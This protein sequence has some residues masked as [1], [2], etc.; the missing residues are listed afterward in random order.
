MNRYLLFCLT[1]LTISFSQTYAQSET[2]TIHGFVYDVK[3]NSELIGA[4]VIL[5]LPNTDSAYTITTT[6][7]TGEFIFENIPFNSYELQVDYFGYPHERVSITLNSSD[8]KV[9]DILL[10]EDQTVYKEVVI[11]GDII[12]NQQRG[13][14]LVFNADAYK[15]NPDATA[16]DLIRKMPGIDLSDGTPKA[17]GENIT[18]IYVDGKPFFGDDVNSTLKNLPAEMIQNVEIF[19]EKNEQSRFSGFDDGQTTKTIN[20]VTRENK[21]QGM[22][23]KFYA[24]YGYN[25]D[26]NYYNIG[27]VYNHFKG[28]Q[29]IT[30]LGM[31]NNINIQN[32]S[33]EDLSGGTETRG[34]GRGGA[35]MGM[36]GRGGNNF[37][38]NQ[39][40]GITTTN[41]VGMNYTN[42]WGTN[43]KLTGSYMFTNSKNYQTET[44]NRDYLS[45]VNYGQRYEELNVSNTE[46]FSHR[47]DFR[48]EYQIDSNNY[49]SFSPNLRIQNT[50]SS[51][52]LTSNTFNASNNLLSTS[53]NVYNSENNS[54]NTG[55][56]FLYNHNFQKKGRTFSI[57]NNTNFNSTNGN[58]DLYANNTFVD[59]VDND[60]LRQ[61]GD[62][63]RKGYN[64]NVNVNYTEPLSDMWR[65]QANVGFRLQHTESDKVTNDFNSLTNEYD[66]LNPK[67]SNQFES[68][69]LTKFAGVAVGYFKENFQFNLGTNFQIAD[70]SSSAILPNAYEYENSFKNV[71]PYAAITYT[72]S[73]TKS[74]R[75]R[76][77]TSTNTPSINQLQNV[78]DNSNTMIL[79]TG[80]PNLDQNYDHRFF[81]N[82]R[83]N[84]I[85]KNSNFFAMMMLNLTNDYVGN[86]T[87]IANEEIVIDDI[88]LKP[89]MQYI[90]PINMDGY[91]RFMTHAVYSFRLKPIKSNVNLNMLYSVSN[92][93]GMV[94]FVTNNSLNSRYGAGVNIGSNISEDIDFNIGTQV[95][96]NTLRN[97]MNTASN[98]S[99]YNQSTRLDL[100]YYIMKNLFFNTQLNHQYYTGLS[101]ENN[102]NF[103]LWNMALG[104][105]FLKNNQAE[106]KLS[107]FDLLKQNQAINITQ[108][109][110][111]RQES[112]SNVLTQYFMLTFTYNL[113]KFSGSTSEKDFER[114]NSIN[115]HN[116]NRSHQMMPGD[117]HP[118]IMR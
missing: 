23:G 74:L 30:V 31:T 28:N 109:Q 10:K 90:K 50:E 85:A 14:T 86:S 16:E 55:Y 26:D 79:R 117:G 60:E 38:V 18:K 46:E 58:T 12:A 45:E 70:I 13:D 83:A 6:S 56:N 76:Y 7:E 87:Y 98:N 19:D 104:Y 78:I 2:G 72:I 36:R 102:R 9:K 106:I 49:I 67:L 8:L 5:F 40:G 73:K 44:L 103:L 42:Q 77:S 84:N 81:I 59:T 11:T 99:F 88:L 110:F 80:N 3:D 111:Y 17:Q 20:F 4:D 61:L 41:A 27:G 64:T 96:Y 43:L 62:N 112:I 57:S 93:P 107:V 37:M 94:N 15:V 118:P 89:G 105:K 63:E 47:F 54:I 66:I 51:S 115:P 116:P 100:N 65:M 34:S 69:Y 48:L 91:Y 32:F 68:D 108:D 92:T 53:N 113:R 22:F 39:R 29:R 75:F 52:T 21:R 82:Y 24:G 33:S 114:N 25:S 35:G 1:F 97:S 95:S 71:L 101:D